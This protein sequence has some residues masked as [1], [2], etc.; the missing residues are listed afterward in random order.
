MP[1]RE[2]VKRDLSLEESGC[3]SWC[4]CEACC[5]AAPAQS[6]G[7]PFN[8]YDGRAVLDVLNDFVRDKPTPEIAFAVGELFLAGMCDA[9]RTREQVLEWLTQRWVSEY[10]IRSH[11]R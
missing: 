1:N 4:S 6:E 2:F 9:P 7:A 8:R 3:Y 10:R 11:G 5:E